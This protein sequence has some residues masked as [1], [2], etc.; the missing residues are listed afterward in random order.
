MND[1]YITTDD[2]RQFVERFRK[3]NE[4]VTAQNAKE[5]FDTFRA[6]KKAWFEAADFKSDEQLY[7]HALVLFTASLRK[8]KDFWEDDAIEDCEQYVKEYL[9]VFSNLSPRVS[10]ELSFMK[11]NIGFYFNSNK[12]F[13]KAKEYLRSSVYY[14]LQSVQQQKQ[15]VNIDCYQY[16]PCD[17][18]LFQSLINKTLSLSS[19]SV[20]NDVFDT[21]ILNYLGQDEKNAEYQLLK[22]VYEQCVKIACFTRKKIL[23]PLLWSHYA[24][25]HR[26]ICVK[27]RFSQA[28]CESTKTTLSFLND[29]EYTNDIKAIY[30]REGIGITEA[31]FVKSKD[32]KYENELRYVHFDENDDGNKHSFVPMPEINAV[33]F[34]VNCNEE[35]KMA[36]F[37]ILKERNVEFYQMR[38]SKDKYGK[39]KAIKW[40]FPNL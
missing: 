22:K 28:L 40:K 8:L 9:D 26:G 30:Q 38:L 5:V 33:Y 21:P 15:Y 4:G 23:S 34:G 36:I 25:S 39:L 17:K 6:N 19:P 37:N 24:D 20:F 31:F 14:R 35:D 1:S 2:I 18:Y 3:E 7:G 10:Y 29:V 16:K 32:W 11:F 13:E 27:Y 12:Q